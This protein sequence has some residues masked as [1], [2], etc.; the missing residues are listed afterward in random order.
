MNKALQTE[1]GTGENAA[2]PIEELTPEQAGALSTELRETRYVLG[3]MSIT[4]RAFVVLLD[5]AGGEKLVGVPGAAARE[6]D[7]AARLKA[8]DEAAARLEARTLEIVKAQRG[9]VP[10]RLR[11]EAAKRHDLPPEV[12]E[13]LEGQDARSIEKS[14]RAL[15]EGLAKAAAPDATAPGARVHSFQRGN[16]VAW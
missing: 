16:E 5:E 15:V 10:A 6:T 1:Q 14:A 2:A 4:R 7:I 12:A 11:A 3:Q 8:H 9:T 13:L